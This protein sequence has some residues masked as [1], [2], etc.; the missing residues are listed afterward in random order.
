LSISHT[1]TTNE[2]INELKAALGPLSARDEKYCSAAC[3][4][5]YLEARNWNVA[6][7]RKMLEESLKWRAAYRPE[8]I[9]W[10]ICS[11][12]SVHACVAKVIFVFLNPGLLAK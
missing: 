4:T 2:Q 11:S 10:V 8:D 3:L 12:F 9:R 1:T 5:R 6:R 7:S